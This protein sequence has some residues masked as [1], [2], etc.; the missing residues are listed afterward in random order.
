M[1][2]EFVDDHSY[3]VSIAHTVRE[4]IDKYKENHSQI[5]LIDVKLNE[6][7]GLEMV[8]M[9]RENGSNCAIILMSGHSDEFQPLINEA[10]KSKVDHFICKPFKMN[11]IID[12]IGDITRRRLLEVLG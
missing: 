8:N 10:V 11:N 4:G 6:G 12:V 9:L 1:L 3:N 5:I 7:T 2:S